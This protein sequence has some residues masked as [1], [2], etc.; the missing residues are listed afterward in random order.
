M[1]CVEPTGNLEWLIGEAMSITLKLNH[2]DGLN[3]RQQMA[4]K[5]ERTEGNQV[6]RGTEW[7]LEPAIDPVTGLDQ[8]RDIRKIGVDGKKEKLGTYTVHI[9]AGLKNLI[10]SKKGPIV[11]VD[12]RNSS[13]RNQMR[14]KMQKF[15]TKD[16]KWKDDGSAQYIPPNSPYGVYVGDGQRAILDEMPT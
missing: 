11:S 8:D 3:L 6:V 13:L 5:V 16:K 12:F 14:I 4:N 10:V 7:K 9:T 2:V 15:D 1:V